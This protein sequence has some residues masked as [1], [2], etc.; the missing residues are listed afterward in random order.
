MN[1]ETRTLY[2]SFNDQGGNKKNIAIRN[3]MMNISATQVKAVAD[4]IIKNELVLG[5]IGFLTVYN[6]AY[7]VVRKTQAVA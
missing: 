1:K 7:I 6:G 2:L 4:D 3:P 5:E